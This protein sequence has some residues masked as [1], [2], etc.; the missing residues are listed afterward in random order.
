MRHLCIIYYQ[1]FYWFGLRCNW[2]RNR[3]HVFK[4]QFEDILWIFTPME[5]SCNIKIINMRCPSPAEICVSLSNLSFLPISIPC[6]LD[7]SQSLVSFLSLGLVLIFYDFYT[8]GTEQYRSFFWTGFFY[9][10]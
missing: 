2:H 9:S 7:L 10:E 5:I 6:P 3:I 4:C 1:D 8:N